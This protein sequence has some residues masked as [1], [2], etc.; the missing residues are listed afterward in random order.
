M[1]IAPLLLALSSAGLAYS[2]YATASTPFTVQQLINLNKMHSTTV[3]HDGTKLVYG[4]KTV[5]DK[6]ESH[7][8]L[9][10]LDLTQANAKPLQLT[11]A[12]GTEHD[13][14]FAKDDSAIYFLANRSGTSQLYKLSLSG[15][16]AVQ[17]SDLPLNIDGYK[18]ANDG[19]QIVLSMRVFPECADLG[20][21]KDKFAQEA[22]RKSTGRE[23]QQLMVRHWDT[24]EDHARNHLFV[25]AL[26]GE[27]LTRVVDITQGL[28]TETPPK[29]FSGME[30]VTFTPDGKHVVYSAKAPSKDQAWTTNYD[31]WQVPVTG[32]S[33]VNLTQDNLAWDAQPTFSSDGRYMAYL[34][35]TKPGFEA[36]RYR[37]MLRDVSTGQS[38]EVAPLW[39]RSPSS[40][41]FGP[42]N[43]TLYVTA[44][45]MGQVS[46]FKVNTQFGD[47][48]SIYSDGTNSLIAVTQDQLIFD[49]KTLVEPGDLYRINTDG[50]ALKRLTAV[51]QAKLA[52][53]KFG[54]FQQFSFKGWNNEDVYGYWIKPANYQE[55]KKYPIAYLVHGGPQGSFG[56]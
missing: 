40:L 19:K 22:A 25:G 11:A 32:G 7:S 36:D 6:G 48:E 31:L 39:D 13:V 33:A 21:S 14:S 12:A 2:S 20:C 45:D 56:N 53:I 49:N 5:N 50:Q 29:P 8:E 38:K 34:A 44:Q 37:I 23:Y 24:W 17:V 43:R 42:D 16:E 28:D 10:L 30:E 15:G 35:M 55:G 51:N 18:L 1:K 4:L 41:M 54:E 46:I 26:T 52:E 9:Y 3:S 47:V 27:K